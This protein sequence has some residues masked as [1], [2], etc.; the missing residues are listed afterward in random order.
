MIDEQR[1]S[2]GPFQ[3]FVLF[4]SLFVLISVLLQLTIPLPEDINAILRLSDQFICFFFFIDFA[5]QLKNAPDRW[6]YFRTWGWIDLISSIPFGFYPQFARIVRL[7]RLIRVIRSVRT[8]VKVF[9]RNK[10]KSS[11]SF[12]VFVSILMLT[13]G[14]IALLLLEQ[15][16]EDANIHNATDAFWWAFVTITTVGYGDYYPVT[17]EGRFVAAILMTT[18]VGLFGTFTGFV[19]SWFLEDDK[20]D[21]GKHIMANLK[22]EVVELR[23]EVQDLKILLRDLAQKKDPD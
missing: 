3:V 22:D 12:V 6:R 23:Q 21:Q 10:V 18:G 20:E 14:A 2:L 8:L 19:A 9:M 1:E 17:V 7:I 15:G 5:I 11:F 16:V 4:L 13:V